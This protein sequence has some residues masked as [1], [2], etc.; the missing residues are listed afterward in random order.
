M[1]SLRYSYRKLDSEG[2]RLNSITAVKSTATRPRESLAAYERPPY[3]QISWSRLAPAAHSA[4]R[5]SREAALFPRVWAIDFTLYVAVLY[6][7]A[8]PPKVV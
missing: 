6:G 2:L 5:D 4:Q 3:R 1:C 7:V 8:R